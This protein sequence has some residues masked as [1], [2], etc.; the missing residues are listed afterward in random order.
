MVNAAKRVLLIGA[1]KHI[2]YHVLEMLATQPDEYALFVLARTPAASIASFKGKENVTFV[3]CDAKDLTTVKDI[4]Q[5]TMN[6][7]IDYIICTVG[8]I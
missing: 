7:D 6:W 3:K 5:N 2:G 8:T 4:L 1:S